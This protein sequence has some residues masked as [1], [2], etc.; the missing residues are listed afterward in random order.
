MLKKIWFTLIELLVV[1]AIIAILASMLLPALNKAR[2]KAKDIKCT[3][4]LKQIGIYSTMYAMQNDGVIVAPNANLGGSS[5]WQDTLMNAFIRP[6]PQYRYY[7]KL[8]KESYPRIHFGVFGCPASMPY[9]AE[10]SRNYAINSFYHNVP[11]DHAFYVPG[12]CS[13]PASSDGARKNTNHKLEHIRRPSQRC[14]FMDIDYNSYTTGDCKIGVETKEAMYYS[15]IDGVVPELR[16]GSGKALNI[17]YADGHVKPLLYD[18]IPK[19]YTI[20]E[21]GYFWGTNPEMY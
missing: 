12:Y 8:T 3:N 2:A 11:S 15:D 14:A 10:N 19:D 16:H 17:C 6:Y 4:N 7:V 13:V 9:M 5:Y 18:L 20:E 1:I 21:E